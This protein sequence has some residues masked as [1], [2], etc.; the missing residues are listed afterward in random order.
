MTVTKEEIDRE[1][2]ALPTG[3]GRFG[4]ALDRL[5]E[6]SEPDESLVA[7]CV[8]L[9][10]DY[11]HTVAFAPGSALNLASLVQE[12]GEATNVV[13]ACT[14][15]RL[16]LIFTGLSGVPRSHVVLPFDGTSIAE[17]DKKAFVL[18]HNGARIQFRGAAKRPAAR[19]LDALAAKLSSS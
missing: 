3:W 1:K 18:E 6:L 8:T 9:N 19:L 17:R 10:P 13:V 16:L 11:H 2:A 5:M 4:K 7:T 12:A 14:D 15:R